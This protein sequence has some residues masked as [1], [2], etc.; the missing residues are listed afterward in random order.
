MKIGR[1]GFFQ[2]MAAAVAAASVLGVDDPERLLWMPGK[3][4]F[5][6]PSRDI[7]RAEDVAVVEIRREAERASIL[8]PEGYFRYTLTTSTGLRMRFDDQWRPEGARTHPEAV[9][10]YN[11]A[12]HDPRF[13]I[14]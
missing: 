4:T 3:K 13:T 1:R 12:F 7:L 11:R 14:Y 2:T 6:L 9:V 8:K 10:L 5:F